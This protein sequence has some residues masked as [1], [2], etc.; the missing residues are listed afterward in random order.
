MMKDAE[1]SCCRLATDRLPN[2]ALVALMVATIDRGRPP[3]APPPPWRAEPGSPPAAPA[4]NGR[5]RFDL[6]PLVVR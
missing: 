1:A 4:N 2:E 3:C 5:G 6:R